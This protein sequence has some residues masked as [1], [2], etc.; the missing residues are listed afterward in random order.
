MSTSW[1]SPL[2]PYG[3]LVGRAGAAGWVLPAEVRTEPFVLLR[4][5]VEAQLF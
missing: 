5:D 2:L 3:A 1:A 4:G